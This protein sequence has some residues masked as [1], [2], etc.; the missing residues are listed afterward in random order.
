[1][2]FLLLFSII[3]CFVP[4]SIGTP[5][6]YISPVDVSVSLMAVY[7]FGVLLS[8]RGVVNG[9][10]LRILIIS[11]LSYLIIIV[12]TIVG[13]NSV[14][15]GALFKYFVFLCIIPFS[16]MIA[17]AQYIRNVGRMPI[18]SVIAISG[19]FLSAFVVLQILRG[20]YASNGPEE[21]YIYIAGNIVHKNYI[22]ALLVF[23]SLSSLWCAL[24]NK[25]IKYIPMYLLQIMVT[26]LIGNRSSFVVEIIFSFIILLRVR[27]NSRSI[28]I[29]IC[30]VVFVFSAIF[31]IQ[32]MGLFHAQTE[33]L[34]SLNEVGNGQMSSASARLW[35][36]SYAWDLI[37][38]RPIFGYGFGN[39]LY[40]APNWLN[41][42][43]EPHNAILQILYA[44]GFTGAICIYGMIFWGLLPKRTNSYNA[45]IFALM[46]MANIVNAMVGIIWIRGEGHLFWMLFF[47]LAM[48][49]FRK[50]DTSK[51]RTI[52]HL[53]EP[54]N[55]T[56]RK[57]AGA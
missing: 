42:R 5:V 15:F 31:I 44:V 50:L 51:N 13:G 17:K 36:W 40:I 43:E 32:L 26:I 29:I 7:S 37:V 3:L 23:S 47:I 30:S 19:S 34:L 4:I 9:R 18:E 11:S 48:G 20:Q 27:Q 12:C 53:E 35:L 22:G 28:V 21:Y 57:T 14:D 1:M 39:F 52:G 49:Y 33:R 54:N 16:L 8:R 46:V 45:R 41:G 56:P 24:Q 6:G 38:Q 25:K 55:W 10:D 2:K